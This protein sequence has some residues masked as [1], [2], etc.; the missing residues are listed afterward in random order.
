LRKI[1]IDR[2]P[3]KTRLSSLP[4]NEEHMSAKTRAEEKTVKLS[5]AALDKARSFI[6]TQARP[7]ERALYLY[8]FAEGN[9]EPV[10]SALAE[11]QNADGGFGHGLEPDFR[12]PASSALATTVGLQI[13]REVRA[14]TDHP[15]VQSAMRYL[16]D[17]YDPEHQVWPII[18]STADS[19]PHAPWWGYSENIADQWGGFL[20]NPR[21]E[22]VGY[23]HEHAS[24]VPGDLLDRLTIAQVD[25]LDET[26]AEIVM[27]DLT[28]YARLAETPALPEDV[29]ELIVPRVKKA[30]DRLV[31]R[32]PKQWHE[33]GLKPIE[34]VKSPESPFIRGLEREV[35]ANLDFEIGRQAEDGSWPPAW[36]WDDLH[37]ETWPTAE[38]EW[39]GVLTLHTLKVLRNFDRLG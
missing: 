7:L 12:L 19:A 23:L 8:H 38:A 3:D 22:I 11:F 20:A 28:C 6:E 39:K 15:L 21:A 16:L 2:E 5:E 4:I 31:V 33:Y 14:S 29:R 17:T 30:F 25:H 10:L 1:A 32:D 18:P 26:Q 24:L 35:E 27:F 34:I 13:L 37:P 36:T 9:P